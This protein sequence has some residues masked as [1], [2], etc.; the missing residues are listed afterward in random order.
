MIQGNKAKYL[1][2]HVPFCNSICAYCDFTRTIY[3]NDLANKWLEAV[4][5]ELEFKNINEELKTIYIGG[6]TPSS[7]SNTQLDTL[8]SYLDKYTNNIIEYTIEINPES[9]N[10][11]KCEIIKRHNINRVS[12]GF[13]TSNNT[14]LKRIGRTHTFEDVY[15]S[16]NILNSFDI[17]N[18]SLDIIYALPTQTI[19]D[20]I[21]TVNDAISLKPKHLSLYSLQIED[22][23]I[24]GKQGLL[25]IDEDIEAD[26]YDYIRDILPKNGYKQ[27]EVSNFAL[28]GYESIH[29]KAYWLYEDYYGISCG[30]SGKEN[31]IL[32]DKPNSIYEY[33]DDPTFMYERNLYIEDEM[34]DT[35]MM[36]LRLVEGI[37]IEAFED[38]YG[39]D[40]IE[41]YADA[42]NDN[43]NKGLLEIVDGH[44]RCKGKSIAVLNDILLDFM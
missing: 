28:E 19:N 17:T 25:P 11:E 14:L 16:I 30:A 27:Y 26:M 37:N 20:L 15:N 29:N 42:I 36:G 43:I 2:L 22:N 12:I 6:G 41:E 39:I 21:V 35:I 31:H 40:M 44:L 13:Q 3:K 10:K 18:Y 38:R 23:S 4:Y 34:F 8:L 5:K 32:Y 9:F 1:Y 24:F 7:L 33:I